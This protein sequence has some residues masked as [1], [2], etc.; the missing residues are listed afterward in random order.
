MLPDAQLANA[1]T[2]G[3]LLAVLVQPPKPKKL[4]EE[5]AADG[6]LAGLPNVAVYGRRVTP[7]DKHKTAGRWKVIAQE[8]EKRGLP[9]TGT[10][11]YSKSVERKWAFQ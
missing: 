1:N 3:G 9:V 11:G 10:G 8:L 2:V 5:L 4:A 7:I 6:E